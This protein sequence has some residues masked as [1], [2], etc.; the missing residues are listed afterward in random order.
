M[1]V[2]WTE[3][4]ILGP[5]RALGHMPV[6]YKGGPRRGSFRSPGASERRGPG[7]S[8]RSEGPGCRAAR[9]TAPGPSGRPGAPAGRAPSARPGHSQP[10]W[11]P[12]RTG[13]SRH[14]RRTW[15]RHTTRSRTPGCG[16]SHVGASSA[17]SRR[18]S[19]AWRAPG[20]PHLVRRTSDRLQRTEARRCAA[21]SHQVAADGACRPGPRAR[22]RTR[23]PDSQE[24][25]R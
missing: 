12:D 3:G 15:R 1:A 10:S 18:S 7:A 24:C 19:R 25:C 2:E 9:R 22:D 20:G 11:R 23:C 17:P 5:E 4:A 8:G 21:A 13:T 16:C 6:R 14:R